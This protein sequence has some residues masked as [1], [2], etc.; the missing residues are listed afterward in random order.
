MRTRILSGKNCFLLL[1]RIINFNNPLCQFQSQFQGIGKTA[2]NIF[3]NHDSIHY[4]INVML[5]FFVQHDFFI[6]IS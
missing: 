1:F 6:Q 5:A 4:H 3:L 2:F